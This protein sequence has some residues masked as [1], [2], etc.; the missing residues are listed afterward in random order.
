[1]TNHVWWLE[2]IKPIILTL[3]RRPINGMDLEVGK[4]VN[5]TSQ[6]IEGKYYQKNMNIIPGCA[7]GLQLTEIFDSNKRLINTAS[8]VT[9]TLDCEN[10]ITLVNLISQII[11]QY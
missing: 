1:M 2:Q 3:Q 4:Y 11:Q 7:C 10:S 5:F 6:L 9:G 8:M